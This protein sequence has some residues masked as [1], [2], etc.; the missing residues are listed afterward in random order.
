MFAHAPILSRFGVSEKP[1]AIQAGD[2]TSYARMLLLG[3]RIFWITYGYEDLNGHHQMRRGAGVCA[4]LGRL[5]TGASAATFPRFECHWNR[6]TTSAVH[7][8][9]VEQFIASFSVPPDE[10]G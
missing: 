10:L 1:G 7:G 5:D 8:L 9:L 4:A 2:I 3:R 6:Q